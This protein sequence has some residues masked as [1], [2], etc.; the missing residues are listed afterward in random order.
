MLL[1]NCKIISSKGLVSGDILIENGKI[2]EIKKNIEK[3][4]EKETNVKGKPVIPG[5]VD[6][7]THMRD[8]NEKKKEDYISGSKAALAGGV[9]TFLDMPNTKPPVTTVKTFKLR[10]ETANRN[11]LTDFG[12]NFGISNN[13]NAFVINPNG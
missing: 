10:I 3:R 11:S 9:T 8:F 13:I 6:A 2:K 4:G 12:I 7:H 5:L 1:R